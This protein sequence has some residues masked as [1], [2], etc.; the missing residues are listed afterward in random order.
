MR[1]KGWPL[2]G[3]VAL[4]L[5]Y[6]GLNL[7]PLSKPH[8]LDAPTP[9]SGP[10]FIF[11]E[12]RGAVVQPGVYKM[13]DTSRVFELFQRAGGLL[14]E[15][16]LGEINQTQVI[17]DGQL[18]RVPTTAESQPS[19]GSNLVSLN[20]ASQGELEQLP[21]IGP[22]TAE[23]IIEARQVTPFQTIEDLLNVP[24]IGPTTLTNIRALITP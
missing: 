14:D 12:V 23:A 8:T 11:V 20:H 22:A 16:F 24:G 21:G 18:I 10:T 4:I 2:I 19:N 7:S 17:Q 6:L 13:A 15:A 3:A 5:V 1:K 9:A